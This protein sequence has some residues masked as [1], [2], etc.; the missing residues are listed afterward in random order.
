VDRF[1]VFRLLFPIALLYGCNAAE[2]GAPRHAV[3]DSG[4]AAP[5]NHRPPDTLV[6]A[7]RA[8]DTLA[9][10]V[11][12]PD[13]P[14]WRISEAPVLVIGSMDGPPESHLHRAHG[15]LRL[16]D[17]RIVVANAG[18]GS[19]LI[20]DP[21][22]RPLRTVGRRGRG[23]GEF[24]APTLVAQ[25]RGDSLVVWDVTLHRLSVFDREG[26]YVRSL[27][28]PG[29]EG[30]MF[31]EVRGVF[32]DGSFVLTP[33]VDVLALSGARGS[34][35]DSL[36]FVRVGPAGTVLDTLGRFP[37]DETYVLRTEHGFA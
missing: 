20:F 14:R 27:S 22:G 10:R 25:V 16:R 24:E 23:P 29:L 8:G 33:G 34:R 7:G 36:T 6:T 32:P 3:R 26:A 9:S 30:A 2:N 28:P 4:G 18:T 19:L 17:G 37:G 11:R 31:P 1:T 21:S 12:T 15:A 13:A 5:V 35:R